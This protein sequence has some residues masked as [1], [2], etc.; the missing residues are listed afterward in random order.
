MCGKPQRKLRRRL[1]GLPLPPS[2]WRQSLSVNLQDRRGVPARVRVLLWGG[3]ERVQRA[4]LRVNGGYPGEVLTASWYE[5]GLRSEKVFAW[6]V[7]SRQGDVDDAGRDE[8]DDRDQDRSSTGWCKHRLGA[9][10]TAAI[11]HAL[12]YHLVDVAQRQAELSRR[13]RA[14]LSDILTPPMLLNR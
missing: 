3:E 6:E 1:K 14:H 7:D 4:R 2:W 13:P 9:S 12:H 5:E 10:S 8:G 11:L